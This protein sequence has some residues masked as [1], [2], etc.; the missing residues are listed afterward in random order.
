[1]KQKP[2]PESS[3]SIDGN[4]EEWLSDFTPAAKLI[5]SG[6]TLKAKDGITFAI[7]CFT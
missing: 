6:I 1:M 3:F 4:K 2:V 7:K 5:K